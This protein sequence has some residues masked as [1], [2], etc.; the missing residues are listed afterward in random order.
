VQPELRI[1]THFNFRR[2]PLDQRHTPCRIDTFVGTKE[3][4]DGA[5]L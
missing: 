1:C 2:Y 3:A 5:L 4:T